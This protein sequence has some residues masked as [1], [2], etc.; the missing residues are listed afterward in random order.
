MSEGSPLVKPKPMAHGIDQT[1]EWIETPEGKEAR[2][3]AADDADWEF[4]QRYVP[5]ATE[6]AK[7]A[8]T[9]TMTPEEKQDVF[10][11]SL[12][13]IVKWHKSE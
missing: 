5:H 8:I 6:F 2:L 9:T 4:W 11:A 10:L 12:N 7:A 1:A 13:T 3:K